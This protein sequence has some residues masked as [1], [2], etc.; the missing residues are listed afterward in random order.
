MEDDKTKWIEQALNSLEGSSRA[1]PAPRVFTQVTRLIETENATIIPLQR[2]RMAAAIAASVLLVNVY[3]L[4]QLAQ[5]EGV[6]SEQIVYENQLSN[7]LI[8]SYKLYQ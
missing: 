4:G 6:N 1:K 8:N 5:E 3:V 2:L 7:Q